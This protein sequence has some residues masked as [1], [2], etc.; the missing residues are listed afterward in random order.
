MCPGF[1]DLRVSD[2]MCPETSKERKKKE[3]ESFVYLSFLKAVIIRTK[4]HYIQ[5]Y[6][7]TPFM[8]HISVFSICMLPL[9][10]KSSP[11][12]CLFHSHFLFYNKSCKNVKRWMFATQPSL[13]QSSAILTLSVISTI[14]PLFPPQKILSAK[15]LSSF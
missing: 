2:H 15:Q 9:T 5:V 10:D 4:Q 13:Q 12:I 3:R 6:S 8:E 11:H 7:K 14:P 1:L